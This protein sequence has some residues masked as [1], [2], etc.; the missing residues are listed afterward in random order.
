MDLTSTFSSLVDDG[1]EEKEKS[2]EAVASVVATAEAFEESVVVMVGSTDW[3]NAAKGAAGKIKKKVP[4]GEEF[5]SPTIVGSLLKQ[6]VR[7]LG[8]GPC[9][10]HCAAVTSEG[11]VFTWGLNTNGQLGLGEGMTT[12]ARGPVHAPLWTTKDGCTVTKIAVGK[13]HTLACY[14]DGSCFSAGCGTRGALGRGERKTDLLEVNGVPAPLSLPSSVVEVA[15]GADFSLAACS[16]GT[17]YS[18]GWTE[19]GKLGQ[20]SDGCYNTKDSSIKLTYTASGTPA[21]VRFPRPQGEAPSTRKVVHCSAGKNHAACVCDDGVAFT[22]GDGAY[23]KL[24]HRTQ[25]QKIFPT[26]L[27]GAR[28][29]VVFCADNSTCGL[30]W[31]E[32]RGRPFVKPPNSDGLLWVWGVLRGTQGEGATH[33]VPE[34]ELQGWGIKPSNLA[35]GASHLALAAD[36]N[37]V[38]WAQMPVAHSQLGFGPKG[39]KSSHKPKVLEALEGVHCA[40]VVAATGTTHYLVDASNKKLVESLPV[41]TPSEDFQVEEDDG[42]SSDEPKSKKPAKK[43]ASKPAAKRARTS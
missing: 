40:Q 19:F 2:V 37:A 17:L 36:D 24:G 12:T 31:P 42:E 26:Q 15:A 7:Q 9:A 41:W 11:K 34:Y 13:N 33:P 28:F 20:G 39:P 22:W 14:S 4:M 6:C 3:A 18:F 38:A 1:E 27:E 43:P 25:E 10:A 21:R 29:S 16:N 8:V 32:Y 23:G 35:M 30:G 5:N